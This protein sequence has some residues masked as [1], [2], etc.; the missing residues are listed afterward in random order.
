MTTTTYEAELLLNNSSNLFKG[1]GGIVFSADLTTAIPTAFTTATT[2][3]LVQLDTTLWHRLGMISQ[4]D[5]VTF[6]RAT[7]TADDN[8]W[9]YLEPVRTDII[10]D[11]V[12][13]QF[14]LMEVNRWTQE[15]YGMVDLSAVHPDATTGE[16]AW[17]K[18]TL[19]TPVFK[20]V[21][22]MAVDGA[23]T[24]RRYRFQIMP[25]A[26]IV[27]VKDEAWNNQAATAF[28]V[29]LQ[30][31]TDPTLGYAVR[32]VLA[33]PGQKALNAGASFV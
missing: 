3:D 20:R 26:Q 4:K 31:F 29:T 32:T 15:I 19:A 2:A 7:K 27:A 23:G 22:H 25:K 11:T 24:N 33:G 28:P 9:G 6:A 16:V 21:V 17:N 1:L 18:P 13:S 30:A 12:S 10:S 14:T 5:G 8:A